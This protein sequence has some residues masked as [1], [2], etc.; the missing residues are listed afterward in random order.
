MSPGEAEA[1]KAGYQSWFEKGKGFVSD[2]ENAR[3]TSPDVFQTLEKLKG[4][5][6]SGVITD[7]EFQTKKQKLLSH[8]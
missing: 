5:L 7:G 8:I 4:L 1:A 3:V 2:L 6:D